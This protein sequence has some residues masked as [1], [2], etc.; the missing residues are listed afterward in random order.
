MAKYQSTLHRLGLGPSMLNLA[1]GA[2][3][4][5]YRLLRQRAQH[6]RTLGNRGL[7]KL[8]GL[9]AVRSGQMSFRWTGG[10]HLTAEFR[11]TGGVHLNRPA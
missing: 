6:C 2:K 5:T 4:A 8:A 9:F 11:W 1:G 3:L 10:V 7:K